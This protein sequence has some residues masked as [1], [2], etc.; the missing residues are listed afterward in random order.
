[1]CARSFDCIRI[2]LQIK[3]YINAILFLL[4]CFLFE[5]YYTYFF[6]YLKRILSIPYYIYLN[7]QY[8]I[9][10]SVHLIHII[11]YNIINFIFSLALY[12]FCSMNYKLHNRR[13]WDC[14]EIVVTLMRI[15]WSF[16]HLF[17]MRYVAHFRRGLS[18]ENTKYLL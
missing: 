1:M 4:S 17:V 3:R 11:F 14:L 13:N 16:E 12:K 18:A 9:I 10:L 6:C 8:V 5:Y 7:L 15:F 2:L